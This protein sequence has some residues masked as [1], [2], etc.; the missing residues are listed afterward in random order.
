MPSVPLRIVDYPMVGGSN[1]SRSPA[2]DSQY[3]QNW[4]AFKDDITGDSS[5]YPYFGSRRIATFSGSSDFA[6]R[7][8]GCITTEAEAFFV[9]GETFYKTD[10][11]FSPAT[12][13]TIG[14][15]SGPVKMTTAGNFLT[16]VDG[17]G[18]Y[19]YDLTTGSFNPITSDN[20]P[21]NSSYVCQF[22]GLTF[23]NEV[24]TQKLSQSARYNPAQAA[25]L[26]Y[27]E[28]NYLSCADSYP[29][30][31]MEP[32]NS[33]VFCLTSGFIQGYQEAGKAGF[34]LRTDNNLIFEYGT[35][36]STC[37]T[38]MK[39]GTTGQTVP[40]ALMFWTYDQ[41]IGLLKAMMTTGGAPRVISTPS[42][43]YRVGQLQYPEDA[44]SFG[45]AENGQVFWQTSWTRD[46]LTIAYNASTKQWH[47]VAFRGGRHFAESFCFFKGKRLVTSY[48]DNHLYE[49]TENLYTNDGEA[50]EIIRITE[51][52]RIPGY[53]KMTAQRLD[54]F[55][56]TGVG[57]VGRVNPN[58]PGFVQGADPL[59]YVYCSFDGGQTWGQPRTAS[60]GML[61]ERE[62]QATIDG[63]G[64]ARDFCFKIKT[65]T[66]VPVFLMGAQLTYIAHEGTQ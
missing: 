63:I 44:V 40:A 26:N 23:F 17:D 35:I 57:L 32:V 18:K 37:V 64:D 10:E 53:K 6:G 11:T 38:K 50:I 28:V 14:T 59:I 21:A 33:R 60:L 48:R 42:I 43:E 41:D 56:Q 12:V 8:G 51:N 49:L 19:V 45:V 29:L 9:V 46:G 61:G 31:A 39:S 34:D 58:N 36:N 7:P 1:V 47:D 2:A 66:R 13:G 15:T 54:F 30:L 65:L 25:P 16:L 3:S 22:K 27:V 62:Y 5:M 24:G 20:L 52:F 55:F 4:Y